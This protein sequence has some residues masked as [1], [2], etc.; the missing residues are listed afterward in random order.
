MVR[1]LTDH[2][3]QNLKRALELGK[4]PDG[5]P[6]NQEQREHCLQLVLAYDQ[7]N[8]PEEQRVGFIHKG[9]K[10]GQSCDTPTPDEQLISIKQPKK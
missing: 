8:L 4:W 9:K 10:E 2:E 7:I 1:N 5:S 6:L 3:Y